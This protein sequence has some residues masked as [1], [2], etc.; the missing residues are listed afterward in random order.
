MHVDGKSLLN[1]FSSGISEAIDQPDSLHE[2][3]DLF[4]F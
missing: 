1:V 2:G 4:Y 3:I